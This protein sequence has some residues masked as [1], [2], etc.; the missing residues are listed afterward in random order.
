MKHLID[1]VRDAFPAVIE[2]QVHRVLGLTAESRG[3]FAPVGGCCEITSPGCETT[4]T[5]C[6]LC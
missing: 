3:L 2:G 4:A 1:A 6:G 5:L